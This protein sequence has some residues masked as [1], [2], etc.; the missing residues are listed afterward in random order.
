VCCEKLIDEDPTWDPMTKEVLE[1]IFGSFVVVT[2]KMFSD[3][4]KGGKYN[5]L[6]TEMQDE[7]KNAPKTNIVLER[8][9]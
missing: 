4:L 1:L 6:D 9:F 5:K 3:H 7:R 2:K 8:D